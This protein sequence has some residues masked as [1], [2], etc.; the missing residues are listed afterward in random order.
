VK[1]EETLILEGI[2]IGLDRLALEITKQRREIESKSRYA[3]LPEWIDMEQAVSLKR[4]ICAEK[5]RG[6]ETPARGVDAGVSGG[7]SIGT[8]RTSAFLQPCCG[9][10]YR[11]VGGRKCWRK[12]DVIEW[13]FITDEELSRYAEKRGVELPKVYRRRGE[14]R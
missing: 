1:A 4:G 7:A 14:G 12:E 8:Y 10:N 11:L 6:R 13:L 9:M 3:E 2:Q 5:K